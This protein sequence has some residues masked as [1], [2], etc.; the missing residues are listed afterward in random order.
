MRTRA[1]LALS[2]AASTEN[3]EPVWGSAIFQVVQGIASE[4]RVTDRASDPD[5]DPLAFSIAAELDRAGIEAALVAAG[6]A[7][8]GADAFTFDPETM[9]LRY[10][11]RSL[12]ISEPPEGAPDT[13]VDL[14]TGLQIVADDGRA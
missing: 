9:T 2:L 5:G 3:R 4:L 13:L 8:S 7:A 12:G 14:P 11:G 6:L 1:T 10:D